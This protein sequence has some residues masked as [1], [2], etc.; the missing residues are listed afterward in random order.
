MK[1]ALS[2]QRAE[3]L[4]LLGKGSDLDLVSFLQ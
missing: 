3:S 1:G 4:Q 2:L